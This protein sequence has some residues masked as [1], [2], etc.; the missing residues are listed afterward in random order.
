[1]RKVWGECGYLSLRQE[2]RDS[3]KWE[4][5]RVR[6]VISGRSEGERGYE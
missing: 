6:E 2:R 3:K 4:R 5:F 1:M